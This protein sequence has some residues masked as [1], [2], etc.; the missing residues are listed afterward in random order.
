M[1]FSSAIFVFGF[2]PLV[3][4]CY[5]IAPK[6]IKNYVLLIFS[7]IFYIFGGPKF[8]VLLLSV[9]LINYLGALLIDKYKSKLWLVVTVAL[10]LGILGYFKYLDFF[11]TSF[12]KVFGSHINTFGII[13]PIGISFYIFQALGYT[14]DVYRK[15]VKV[16][17]NFFLL[18]FY[19]S[20]FPQLVAGPIVR[21]KTVEKEIRERKTSI[22]D[23]S[24]GIERFILGLAKKVII[25]NQVGALADI[26]FKSGSVG[27]LISLLGAIAYM[28]QIYFD[29][30]AYSDMAIG[31]G[32]VFGFHFLE[33][34]NFPYIASSVTDFWRRWHI[35]LS[36]FFR[37]Y[38][39]IPLGGNR[40]SKGRWIFNIFVV[41]ALTGLWHGASWNF[42]L[43]GLY[44]FVF[45][46]IEKLWL[47]KY[48]EKTKVLKHVYTL[49]IVLFGWVIFRCESLDSIILFTKD[50]FSF[51][52][53]DINTFLIYLE[54]YAIY[55]IAGLI[56]STPIYYVITDK[57]KD[58]VWFNAIKYVGLLG[59]FMISVCFLAKSAFNPFIYFRF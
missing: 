18:L 20:F 35:S 45:L 40:V 30:S 16:Q 37:D 1:V 21:Y 56:F 47:G 24:D 31:I 50:L 54:T 53:G 42:V 26:I 13:L 4:L 29:F 57:F 22:E 5:F 2:L 15:E 27:S 8:I 23:I 14:I 6:K 46:L 58:K 52:L 59:L 19:V 33:N 11:I 48:L 9:V 49:I 36:S 17:K 44:Y 7:L 32:R 34:F 51:K 12:N 28:L 3:F 38:V 10:N 41:W 43:W 39:Y 25:A 55:L